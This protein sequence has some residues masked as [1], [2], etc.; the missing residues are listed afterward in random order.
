MWIKRVLGA[1]IIIPA[2]ALLVIV[3][4][5]LWKNEWSDGPE[6]GVRFINWWFE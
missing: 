5:C 4:Y 3:P 6:W 2:Y 1:Y